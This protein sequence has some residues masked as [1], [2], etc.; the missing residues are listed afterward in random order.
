VE[1]VYGADGRRR[2]RLTQ[3]PE[4]GDLLS[5]RAIIPGA[6][7]FVLWQVLALGGWRLW[8]YALPLA[9]LLALSGYFWLAKLNRRVITL[10]PEQVAVRFEPLP[11]PGW[12][13]PAGDIVGLLTYDA[14]PPRASMASYRP[15][16]L[17]AKRRHGP[18]RALLRN[19]DKH[20]V[21][22]TLQLVKQTFGLADEAIED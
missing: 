13:C 8:T 22:F 12:S 14:D 20:R 9:G 16:T 21:Y 5:P 6:S 4:A 10:G 3:L 19:A 1:Q 15:D 2:L 7:L 11:W 17:I 18:R